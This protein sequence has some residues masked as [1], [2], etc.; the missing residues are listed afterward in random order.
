MC[1]TL[2]N[3]NNMP[4]KTIYRRIV[5][6]FDVARQCKKYGIS[7]WHCPQFIFLIIGVL[8]IVIALFS[9][10]IGIKYV[11]DSR[12]AALIALVT[13][14]F[15]LVIGFVVHQSFE[16]LAEV[17]KIKSEFINTVSHELKDPISNL[18]WTMELLMS[19]KLGKVGKKQTEYFKVLEENIN[20]MKELLRDLIVVSMIET[21]TLSVKEKEF[22]LSELIEELI[23]GF[24][25]V[26]R[27]RKVKISF[28]QTNRLPMIVADPFQIRRVIENLLDNAIRYT[29]DRGEVRIKTE[30]RLNKIYFEIKDSGVG[31][32]KKD[33]KYIFQKFFRA[34]NAMKY[35]T[36]GS[37]LGLYIAK[38]IIENSGGKIGF[39]SQNEKG[40]NFWFILPVK[41]LKNI[42]E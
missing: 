13:S 1:Y 10:F 28:G 22:Y 14:A 34:D 16:R 9:Y 36:R 17:N 35:Q 3:I 11:D 6:Q 8:I 2:I 31:I 27:S 39:F 26:A 12:L 20:R 5:E 21:K 41:K 7:L 23:E 29:K 25:S 18:G 19:G 15:L 24:E 32:P 40:S 4:P 33:Q 42:E 37:G 38:S 30:L